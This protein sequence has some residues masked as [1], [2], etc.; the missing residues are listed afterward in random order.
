MPVRDATRADVDEICALIEEHAAYEDNHDLRL[1]R[2]GMAEHLFGPDPKA[3]VLLAHPDGEPDTVAGFAFCWPTLSTWE[4]KPGIWLDD[5][6]IRPAY[7]RRGFAAELMT[8]LRGRTDGRVEWEMREGNDNAT[9]F[10]A[11]LGA[12]PVTGW[13]QYRWQL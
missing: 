6:F 2:A 1:D 5:L 12:V 3:W 8:A 7:R 13:V 9:A 10:Y 4:G 11:Q